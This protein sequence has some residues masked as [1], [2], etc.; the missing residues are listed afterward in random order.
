MLSLAAQLSVLS[1]FLLKIIGYTIG[2]PPDDMGGTL[3]QKRN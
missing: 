3:F 2:E 1:A